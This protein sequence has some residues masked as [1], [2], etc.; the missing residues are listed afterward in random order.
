MK[1]LTFALLGAIA[2]ALTA[3][4][5]SAGHKQA[6]YYTGPCYTPVTIAYVEKEVTNYQAVWKER[7][8]ETTIYE[9]VQHTEKVP[10]TYTEY[11]P[12]TVEK[13]GKVVEYQ[14]VAKPLEYNVTVCKVTPVWEE[15]KGEVTE[16]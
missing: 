8:V 5:A 12:V 10:F 2:V 9:T 16:Y 1:V 14:M 13:K 6:C 7:E 4:C 11:K 3:N 15:R